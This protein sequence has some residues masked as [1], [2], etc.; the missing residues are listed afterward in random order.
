MWSGN[1]NESRPAPPAIFRCKDFPQ[2][3][4]PNPSG[5]SVRQEFFSRRQA[6]RP[7][8]GGKICLNS[9][10]ITLTFL[11]PIRKQFHALLEFNFRIV[12]EFFARFGNIGECHRHVAELK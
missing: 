1:R 8:Q 12:A 2:K 5:N 9:S 4:R 3:A 6:R 7:K 11:K 10:Y